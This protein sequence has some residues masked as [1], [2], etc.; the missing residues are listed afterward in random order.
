M[1]L[2][3]FKNMPDGYRIMRF[4]GGSKFDM[5]RGNSKN[6]ILNWSDFKLKLTI[7]LISNWTS[8]KKK[9]IILTKPLTK[10]EKFRL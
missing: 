9:K 5:I 1:I 4:F 2:D 7:L 10:L 3:Y 6:Y 8:F